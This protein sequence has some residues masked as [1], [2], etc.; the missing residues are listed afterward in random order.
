MPMEL[1]QNVAT[2]LGYRK[3]TDCMKRS[4][5]TRAINW[6][7]YQLCYQCYCILILKK[8]PPRGMGGKYLKSEEYSDF[9]AIPV[10]RTIL[11]HNVAPKR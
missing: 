7:A 3:G 11:N 9:Q 2:C 10:P 5:S 4:H 8:T 6:R 1:V